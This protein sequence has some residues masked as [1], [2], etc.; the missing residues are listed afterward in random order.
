MIR[1]RGTERPRIILTAVETTKN[2]SKLIE[3]RQTANTSHE[4]QTKMMDFSQ[5]LAFHYLLF[6]PVLSPQWEVKIRAHLTMAGQKL[7]PEKSQSSSG[8]G[9]PGEG[10]PYPFL[11]CP[12]HH[13]STARALAA[14]GP[15]LGLDL[16]ILSH[17]NKKTL[18]SRGSSLSAVGGSQDQ[19][20]HNRK[21]GFTEIEEGRRTLW[22][23]IYFLCSGGW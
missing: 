8:G 21:H 16:E 19:K 11:S 10:I 18:E 3:K 5:N 1:R 22:W 15:G 7:D 2:K 20:S 9:A 13:R 4:I 12:T 17:Q 23:P 6:C 14:W